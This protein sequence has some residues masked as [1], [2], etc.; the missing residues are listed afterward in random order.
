MLNTNERS[1]YHV[2]R[3]ASLQVADANGNLY[4]VV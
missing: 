3:N 4:R 1:I 2:I